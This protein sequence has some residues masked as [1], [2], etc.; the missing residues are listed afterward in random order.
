MEVAQTEQLHE[1]IADGRRRLAEGLESLTDEGWRSPSLC[2]GWTV[3]HVVA[4]LT[5]PFRYSTSRVVLGILKAGGSFTR[6]SDGVAARDAA[7]PRAALTAA[8]RDNADNR[9][10]PPGGGVIGALSH[11]VIHGF[12]I[13]RPTGIEWRPSD[14]ALVAVLD[15]AV[16]TRS[17][18]HFGVALE[19]LRLEAED[20]AWSHSPDPAIDPAASGVRRAPAADLL[21]FLTGRGVQAGVA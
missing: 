4:H 14:G 6:Y 8:L 21:M 15:G 17:L 18:R 12:D 10:T 19:G 3:A 11:D 5:M 2:D 7:L 13:A 1:W 9:W 20:V 16:A